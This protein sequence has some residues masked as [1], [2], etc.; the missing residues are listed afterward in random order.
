MRAKLLTCVPHELKSEL[1]EGKQQKTSVRNTPLQI[2]VDTRIHTNTKKESIKKSMTEPSSG[3]TQK[4]PLVRSLN[5]W[6]L[7]KARAVELDVRVD[8][9]DT[10]AGLIRLYSKLSL[11]KHECPPNV[12]PTMEK[13]R[14]LCLHKNN[15]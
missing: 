7:A 6:A 10:L 3:G 12:K 11:K 15:A 2:F 1:L 4:V 14:I 5:E 8:A 9:S 13:R